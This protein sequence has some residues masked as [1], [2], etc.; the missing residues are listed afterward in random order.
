[1]AETNDSIIAAKELLTKRLELQISENAKIKR[2][3]LAAFSKIAELGYAT[4]IDAKVF[5]LDR[6]NDTAELKKILETLRLW[7]FMEM[8]HA[9]GA[10]AALVED[11][12][13]PIG[14]QASDYIS[15]AQNGLTAKQRIRKYTDRLKYEI[16]G[17]I[18]A[19]LL[20]GIGKDKLQ[21]L[22]SQY[23][24][25]PYTNPAFI[26]AQNYRS[27]AVRLRNGGA[28][29]GKGQTT[30]LKSVERL[31]GWLIADSYR[32]AQADAWGNGGVS[33]FIVGRGSSYPCETCDSM[34]GFHSL[35]VDL[36]PYHANCCC[37]A[38]PVGGVLQGRSSGL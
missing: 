28:H 12:Y 5:K 2:K 4:Q 21:S 18:A 23:A 22:F 29:F 3:I 13:G 16:E 32:K 25:E 37:W 14:F 33:G 7:L 24:A 35:A 27:D 10:S 30:A 1:M 9:T 17:W 34:A 8:T 26:A 6:I 38:A 31:S 11:E 36:P 19:G 15:E 20:L